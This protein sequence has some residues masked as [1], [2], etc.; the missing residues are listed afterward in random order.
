MFGA[1]LISILLTFF[2][3]SD[4]A[5]ATAGGSDIEIIIVDPPAAPPGPPAAPPGPPAA[6]P[7]SVE[8]E[9]INTDVGGNKIPLQ[10]IV[11]LEDSIAVNA[12]TLEDTFQAL[13]IIV[14]GLGAEIFYTYNNTIS[15]FAFRASNQQI[16]EQI[17]SALELD[18]RVKLVEQDQ[19]VVPFDTIPTGVDRVDADPLITNPNTLHFSADTDIAIIDSGTDL[20]HPDLNLYQKTSSII[21]QNTSIPSS[22]NDTLMNTGINLRKIGLNIEENPGAFFYPP[23]SKNETSSA[24]D[25]CGHGTHV[26]G[27]ASAK[28][29]SFGTV[30]IS[31]G[32]R[33]WTIKVLE[34]DEHSGKCEGAMSSVIKA[35]DYVTKNTEEIDVTNL[36]LGCKCNSSALEE[37]I[38]KSVARDVIYV[39]AAGNTH[40][41][42]SSFLPASHDD[43][44]TVSAIADEDGKCGSAGIP[45]WID[46]GNMSGYTTDD[47]FAS[48]SNYGQVIDIAAPGVSINS[49]YIDGTYTIMGGTSTAAPHVTGAI[50]LYKMLDPNMSLNDI[51]RILSDTASTKKTVCNGFGRGYFTEDFDTNAEPLLY[52]FD[53][54]KPLMNKFVK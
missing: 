37:A 8:T 19:T 47:S 44:F 49:T 5:Y 24:D 30:G 13:S 40:E 50:A 48:F 16:V 26:A 20:D 18:P 27:V 11:V 41:D 12:S 42:A 3:I 15:G 34:Y 23:F 38:D 6:P 4:K 46:A 7:F 53:T 25:K 22:S 32:A 54:I 28:H 45:L 36:S 21:P 31:P 17:I 35:M 43:V 39:V 10:Y 29:N 1:L 14:E 33:L 52:L 2:I 51:R 9:K